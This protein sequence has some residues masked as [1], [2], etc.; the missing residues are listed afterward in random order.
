M[1]YILAC[2]PIIQGLVGAFLVLWLGSTA[3]FDFV[4]I[5]LSLIFP[6]LSVVVGLTY[7]FSFRLGVSLCLLLF[8]AQLLH[9][10]SENF[11]YSLSIGVSGM[12][13]Y[14]LGYSMI[15][16]NFVA[17]IAFVVILTCALSK[18]TRIP[19]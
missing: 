7:L 4:V 10:S 16:F 1:K 5:A 2:F 8:G 12:L 6:I 17:G 13:W 15:G 3:G 19:R 18:P 11:E 9:Y 14:N